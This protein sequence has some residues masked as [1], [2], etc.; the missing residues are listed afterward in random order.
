[1]IEGRQLCDLLD[2]IEASSDE[3]KEVQKDT[4]NK[5]R[6]NF[7]EDIQSTKENTPLNTPKK[8]RLVEVNQDALSPRGLF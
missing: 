8:K 6:K 3:Q 5:K 4:N 1:M 7:V 2:E